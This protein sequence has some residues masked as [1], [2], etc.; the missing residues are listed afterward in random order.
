[1]AA[2]PFAPT[3]N[4]RL[5]TPSFYLSRPAFPSFCLSNLSSFSLR[6]KSRLLLSCCCGSLTINGN[7]LTSAIPD[8]SMLLFPLF[9]ELGLNEKETE[10]ILNNDNADLRITSFESIRSRAQLLQCTGINALALSR[11]I[12]KNPYILTSEEI[13]AL[14]SFITKDKELGL[15]GQ[16]KPSQV[17]RLLKA[18]NLGFV[19]GFEEKVRLLLQFGIPREK[20]VHVLNHVNLSKALCAKPVDEIERTLAFLQRFGGVDLIVRRPT[21]LNYD[22]QTQLLPRMGF[23][24]ELS[25]GDEDATRTVV[26]KFPSILSYTVDH[27]NNH[28]EFFNSYAGLSQEEFFRIVLVFPGLFSSSVE[29][30]LQSRIDFLKL[31][32]LSPNDILRFLIKA[33]LFLSLS[34]E[35]NLANKLV[36]LVKLGYENRSRELAYA[37]GAVTRCSCRNVQE[38]IGVLLNYGLTC[39]DIME[40]SVKHPQVLQYNHVS[41]EE[42]M[43]YLV[44]EMGREVREL[45]SFPAFLGYKLDGRIKHRFEEK[46]MVLGDGMSIN[47]LLSMSAVKFSSKGK[48]SVRVD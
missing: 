5:L 2:N 25:G 41:L 46:R 13:G 24:L 6:H 14:L 32:G 35:G 26:R 43:K 27:L 34:F 45:L 37:M 1:M 48:T 10:S 12:L 15:K 20:L 36:V 18:R 28:V 9:Q 47:K 39:E 30:K 17:E 44:E 16:M 33:P 23:L 4:S 38:V 21:V 31:C 3:T 19:A 8:L 29:R 11:L 22:L 40:M 42:K 7:Q